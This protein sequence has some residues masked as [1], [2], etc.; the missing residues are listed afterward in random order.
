MISKFFL[1]ALLP[2]ISFLL[3]KAFVAFCVRNEKPSAEEFLAQADKFKGEPADAKAE[4]LSK[5]RS[6]WAL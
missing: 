1:L 2:V 6:H 4:L 5:I 3:A